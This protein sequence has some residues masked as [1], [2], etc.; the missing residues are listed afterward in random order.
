MYTYQLTSTFILGGILMKKTT[1]YTIG[2]TLTL[3]ACLLWCLLALR[4]PVSCFMSFAGLILFLGCYSTYIKYTDSIH[5]SGMLLIPLMLFLVTL[6]D[7][8]IAGSSPLMLL[9]SLL[10]F[11]SLL[12][13]CALALY[14]YV[15]QAQKEL[16]QN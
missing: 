11:T 2:V 12:M 14:K 16:V 7:S 10:G 5:L 9:A 1:D 4:L 6:K 13:I 3:F 15:K 8:L